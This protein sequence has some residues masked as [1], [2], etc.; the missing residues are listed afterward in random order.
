MTTIASTLV[1][2]ELSF[3]SEVSWQA[4]VCL[5]Q[6]NVPTERQATQEDTFC[7]IA[8]ALGAQTFNPSGTAICEVNPTAGSQVTY[9]RLLTA[10]TNGE[11]FSFRV[12]YPSSGS[13]GQ[14]FYL[15]GD[16]KCS[17]LDLQMDATT[18]IKFAFTL[19]GE[20]T[21]DITN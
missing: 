6:Y 15:S 20:G 9:N 13:T 1:P 7:G 2:L 17:S 8:T 10:Q 3:D 21:L 5:Q 12:R 4:L 16:C 11:T 18:Y 14:S 19:T